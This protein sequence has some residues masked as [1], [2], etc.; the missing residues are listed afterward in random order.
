MQIKALA[1]ICLAVLASG[2]FAQLRADD[3]DWKEIDEPA[4]PAFS[5]NR[6]IPV[7]MPA[8]VTLQFGVDPATLTLTK[9][10]VVRYVM[11]ASSPGGATNAMYEGIRCA[12][13]EYRTYARASASGPWRA[14]AYT[15]WSPLDR[16]ASSRAALSLAQQGVCNGR[17][18]TGHSVQA[19]V[20]ALNG[21]R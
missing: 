16:S 8:H 4:A 5:V 21:Q 6:L 2:A 3:P 20:R 9:D 12:T 7:D 18:V 15:A 1:G 14:N 17:S 10:G 11:V 19:I 13:G